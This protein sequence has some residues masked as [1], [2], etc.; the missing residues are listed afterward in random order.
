M[1]A[2]D[3][4]IREVAPSVAS[5]QPGRGAPV[6]ARTIDTLY[7]TAVV[8]VVS[9]FAIA[10][11]HG[12]ANFWQWGHNG[13][14]GAAFCQAARNSL[15]FGILGQAQ[16][17]TDVVP[18]PVSE[19]YT[20]HPMMLHFHLVGLFAVLG[21]AEW[22]GRIVPVGYSILD[23]L[24][25]FVI[26]RR[27]ADRWTALASIVAYGLIPLNL[28]FATMVDHEQGGI[29]WSLVFLYTYARW[30]EAGRIAHAALSF[31]AVTVAVQ[32]DWPGYYFALFVAVHALASGLREGVRPFRWRPAFTYVAVLSCVV[33]SNF[34]AFL[35]IVA[36]ARGGVTDLFAAF[37]DRS[38]SPEGY[39]PRL[40][41]WSLDLQGGLFLTVLAVWI[42]V[43]SYRAWKRQL[44]LGE[45]VPVCFFLAQL[46]HSVVFKQA[47]YVHSYWTYWLGPTL[48][49][50]AGS[51]LVQAV[52]SSPAWSRRL[53]AHFADSKPEAQRQRWMAQ[54][55]RVG[56]A[57]G[58]V[59]VAAPLGGQL[60]YSISRLQWGFLHGFGSYSEPYDDQ[61][62][63]I[64]WVQHVTKD[65]DRTNTF[66]E[67]HPSAQ[68]RIEW[69]Y[70]L[71]APNAAPVEGDVPVVPNVDV[72]HHVVLIDLL[73]VRDWRKLRVLI[74]K[75]PTIVYDQRFLAIDVA[76]PR[77]A[78]SALRHV[79]QAAP[80]WWRWLV[81]PFRPPITWEPSR[82]D[83]LTR[84]ELTEKPAVAMERTFGGEGGL[85]VAWDCPVGFALIGM[86]GSHSGD[87][88]VLDQLQPI[89]GVLLPPVGPERTV[90]PTWFEGPALGFA[91][92]KDFLVTCEPGRVVA[93]L[94]VRYGAL[95][96]AL[97]LVCGTPRVV[98]DAVRGQSRVEMGDVD[99]SALFG[100]PGGR[101]ARFECPP[102]SVGWG[103]R[104]RL[105]MA[106]D[107][108]GLSCVKVDA[109]FR[110]AAR[111]R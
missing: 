19:I 106:F 6:S 35:A 42:V 16:Y 47:G 92:G 41:R 26:V 111:A 66:F 104:G 36:H 10:C 21:D 80:W 48:A 76:S 77:H 46:V 102:G 55:R 3:E 24:A 90:R 67:L 22:V 71:D 17:Y 74:S 28:V 56:A 27:F 68:A 54:A 82:L 91:V 32:F 87:A 62:L 58:V 72:P 81:H 96:D 105:G 34:A 59:L 23:M 78:L 99:A 5:P 89:C 53:I 79:P 39:L 25:V 20:H 29:F 100:G 107:A 15:R 103:L 38:S 12:V 18:P 57:I 30:R 70:Y 83:D 50:A 33:L 7:W 88:P 64:R 60:A 9:V 11:L 4:S 93:G 49:I 75:H 1:I 97:G 2:T 14:N 8:L 84:L 110:E 69:L 85:P 108:V 65:F 44:G 94:V 101:M 13:Y 45:L 31:F 51:M 40:W 61:F 73:F 43:T 63:A 52:R 95:V 109:A 37:E 98:F 86:R